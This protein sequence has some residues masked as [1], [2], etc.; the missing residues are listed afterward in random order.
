MP[1]GIVSTWLPTQ[2]ANEIYEYKDSHFDSWE[3]L[4]NYISG[5]DGGTIRVDNWRWLFLSYFNDPDV[6]AAYEV[7]SHQQVGS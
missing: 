4:Y 7:S 6:K 3:N 1:D 2:I 5:V